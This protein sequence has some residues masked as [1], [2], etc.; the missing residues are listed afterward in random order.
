[1][2]ESQ[3]STG[4]AYSATKKDPDQPNLLIREALAVLRRSLWVVLGVF[5]LTVVGAYAALSL[6]TEQYD[7]EAEVLVKIGRENLDP[8][9]TSRN[10][11]LSAGLR[12]EELMSEIEIL[13]SPYLIE[14][15]IKIVGLDRF[16]AHRIPPTTLI[17]KVKSGVK[18]VLRSVKEQYSEFLIALDLKKRLDEQQKVL[19]GVI[20]SLSVDPVKDSDVIS[21]RLRMPDA[22]LARDVET[23][24]LRQ[25]LN[26][27]VEVRQTTGVKAF[28]DQLAHQRQ[29]VLH[30]AEVRTDQLKQRSGLT[31][32]TEQTSLLLKQIRDLS[33]AEAISSGEIN[34]LVR[35][36]EAS[37]KI[38]SSS[39]EYQ[40][41]AEQQT[42]NPARQSV[43]EKLIGLKLQRAQQ[44]QKYKPESDTIT[45]LDQSIARLEDLLKKENSTQVGSVTMQLNS[46][47][48]AA[49]QAL[50]QNTVRLEGL[51]AIDARQSAELESLK[52]ELAH[53]QA[54]GASLTDVERTRKM[55]ELDYDAVIK[56]KFDSDIST[57]LDKDRVSNVSVSRQPFSSFEPVYPRKLLAMAISIAAGLIFGIGLALLLHY[58]DGRVNDPEKLEAQTQLLHLGTL[59]AAHPASALA[60]G[61][62]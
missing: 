12:H 11:P 58:M 32:P 55:A 1:M 10:L 24:L 4:A 16:Q 45:V 41:G 59:D 42:P 56:R 23:E 19:G 8:P 54:A 38:I 33:G 51:R 13:K 34:A 48:V 21:V 26:W 43:E 44:L 28:L 39:P 3:L 40:R 36:V 61:R 29:N 6:M 17:G 49:Q 50:H 20:D 5:A 62:L 37:E 25:Y 14:K 7:T 60:T 18:G 46:N 30:E 22:A 35:Q 9:A 27:R 57:E 31:S 52:A 47:R 2:A 53:L 15:V